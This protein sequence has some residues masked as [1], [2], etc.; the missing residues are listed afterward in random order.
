[1][2]T[3]AHFK[4]K[5]IATVIASSAVTGM[6]GYA[7]A[8]DQGVEEVVVTGIRASMERAMDVKRESAGV[9]DSINSEDMGKFPDTNLAES[10]QRITG[11]SISRQNGEGSEVTVRGFGSGNN[12][13]T[14]NGRTMPTGTT[15]AGGSGADG[16]TRAGGSRAFNFSNLAS[17]GISAVEV[18]KTG[19]ANIATG[20][21]GATINVKT[22][23][24]LDTAG[25]KATV[26]A[27]ALA[28]TTNEVG[29][30][31]T[32]ELSGLVSWANDSETFGASLSVSSQERDSGSA[33][34]TVNNWNI[35]VWGTNKLY[36]TAPNSVFKN[37]PEV[38]QLY[39]RPNDFRYG[40]SDF[41]RDRLN[42]Q[43][44]LQFRPV[45]NITVTGD[46]TYADNDIT[47]SRAEV[48]NWIQ[49]GSNIAEV[50]FDDSEIATPL[51]IREAYNGTVD[52]G[53]EQQFRMQSNTLES[54]GLNV[55]FQV[56]DEFKLTLDAHDSSMESLPTGPDGS[57]E[58]AIGLGSPTVR[59]KTL[60][61][62]KSIPTY[63]YT[64]SVAGNNIT[65]ANVGSSILRVRGAGSVNDITQLK[66]DGSYEVDGARFDFGVE[67][68]EMEMSAYQTAGVNQTLGN[69]G[70]ANP[71]EFA[72]KGLL[73]QV[74]AAS[75]FDDFDIGNSPTIAFKGNAA[76]LTREANKLY[77]GTCL[78]VADANSSDDVITEETQAI[79]IQGG[80]DVEVANLPVSVLA[81]L[82]Y[83]TTDVTSASVVTPVSYLL[84]ENNND[85]STVFGNTTISASE[86]A[87]Y[88]NLLPSL[89]I[90]VSLTDDL[91][92]RASFGKTIARAGFGDM[93]YS[94]SGFGTTGSSFNGYQA[95][96][97]SGNPGLLPLES[98]NVDFSVE[99]YYADSSYVSAG[100]FEK[101][102]SNFIGQGQ[103]EKTFYGIKDQTSASSSRVQ[104]AA[105]ALR[106]LNMQTDDTNLYAMM[107][108]QAHP[109]ALNMKNAQGNLIFPNGKFEA[110]SEQ[111]LLL[112]ETNGW[113][114]A[115]DG[116]EPEMVFLTSTP[117]NDKEAK[118]YGAEFAVQ[119]FFGETGFGVLAN[120]TLVRG[121]VGFDNNGL[122]TETQFALTGLSDTAN[123][124]L[125][126]EN[127]G[128][129]ARLAYNWRDE[130]LTETNQG[131][132]RNPRYVEAYSQID[133]S[134][135]YELTENLSLSA[136]AINL[137][138]E[139]NR[140]HNRNSRMIRFAD[141]LG[142]RY[143]LGAR[144]KF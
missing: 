92:A 137:T 102:V 62:S 90:K 71:G 97:S 26:G 98:D 44:T 104:T 64:T 22:N 60:D 86:S 138:G 123:L 31:I 42:G 93:R 35:G 57:G 34:V 119:H 5:L 28:D 4:K 144:Y 103:E 55:D 16:T 69:W 125:M 105:S 51:S 81:G 127:Y 131:G 121:D 84:W 113:D 109:E 13:V 27:K 75:L 99:Y 136:E 20:G 87:S 110:T 23:R 118:L 32:P 114:I 94:P 29:S 40:F 49:N 140:E 100:V 143:A 79:Y 15:Y 77:P 76:D 89:D 139:D 111:L 65:E 88:D 72:G 106:S 45:E 33:G 53:Y 58:I 67:S 129:S 120:Y 17:D 6:S 133:L 82:R 14:L 107:V 134:V 12:M 46:Y 91:V 122:P 21:I 1:M 36:D 116:S 70:V 38:G 132:S 73:T 50:V 19:K 117:V 8:Q 108:L 61:F 39:A 101:R 54:F 142:A 9:V 48:T 63:S 96:A 95:T 41:E 3:R 24:P 128:V 74:N 11:V 80:L 115:P 135:S 2:N 18:Y 112:G 141:D 30:D 66:L 85:F 43:L 56:S 130:F 25:F 59:G 78:C 83:E 47:E 68:R 52:V 10:L 7:V 126:Y 124:V 37:A